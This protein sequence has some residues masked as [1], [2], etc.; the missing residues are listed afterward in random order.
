M[1]T[2]RIATYRAQKA[3]DVRERVSNAP[4]AG[5]NRAPAVTVARR[6]RSGPRHRATDPSCS[7]RR[8]SPLAS[9]QVLPRCQVTR[10][11]V[12]HAMDSASTDVVGTAAMDLV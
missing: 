10:P 7:A 4:T 3:T 2:L 12:D 9:P 8:R 6:E 11:E 1:G 5:T